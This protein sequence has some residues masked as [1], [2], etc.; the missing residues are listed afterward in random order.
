MLQ[1]A[2]FKKTSALG[3]DISKQNRPS[4]PDKGLETGLDK[5]MVE[6]C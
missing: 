1:I 6:K 3:G 4:E 2:H 5:P